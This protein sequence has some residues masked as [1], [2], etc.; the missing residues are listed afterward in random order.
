VIMQ[1]R[2]STNIVHQYEAIELTET[3]HTHYTMDTEC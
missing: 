2:F 1:Y 3:Y